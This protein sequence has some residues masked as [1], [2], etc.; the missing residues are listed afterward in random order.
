MENDGPVAGPDAPTA[1]FKMVKLGNRNRGLESAT[2]GFAS[3]RLGIRG[4]K[5]I[6]VSD[7]V[8][9]NRPAAGTQ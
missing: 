2:F 4:G 8:G 6:S 7:V 9:A 5:R 3:D 1:R